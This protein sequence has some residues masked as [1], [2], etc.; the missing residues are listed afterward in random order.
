MGGKYL[1]I[2]LLIISTSYA[3]TQ[4]EQIAENDNARVSV[5]LH[6]VSTLLGIAGF[7]PIYL[8]VEIPF[9]LYN[10]LI[11]RPSY[12]NLSN[13][14][15][16]KIFRI[17][18]DFGYRYYLTGKGENLYLQGQM[19]LFYFR[20]DDHYTSCYYEDGCDDVDANLIPFFSV[21]NYRKSLWLD[22]MGYIGFSFKYVFIDVGIGLIMV[23]NPERVKLFDELWPDLNIGIGIPF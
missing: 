4:E 5:Y 15:G 6:P 1:L 20:G 10:S 7:S 23:I 22:A 13:F 11:I 21:P 16:D 14:D 3:N 9:S 17:G 18:S 2:C 12:L 19:G 8:T